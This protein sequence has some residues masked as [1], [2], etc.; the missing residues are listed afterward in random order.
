MM[1][2]YEKVSGKSLKALLELATEMRSVD[3]N[4]D[5]NK[6]IVLISIARKNGIEA[7]KIAEAFGIPKGTMSN[8]VLSL[9]PY[10]YRRGRNGELKDG[11]GLVVQEPS[12][13]D[14]RAKELHLTLEGK[15]FIDRLIKI[16]AG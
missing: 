1:Q 8:V 15:Q 12:M 13:N 11:L 14:R 2:S 10:S 7:T 16:F 6:L 3:G 9:S 5:A 4:F